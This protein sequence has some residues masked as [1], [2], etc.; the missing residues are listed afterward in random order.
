MFCGTC[1]VAK[2]L[3]WTS[4]PLVLSAFARSRF[5][6]ARTRPTLQQLA[7]PQVELVDPIAVQRARRDQVHRDVGRAARQRPRR[8]TAA[9]ARWSR[10]S[11][12]QSAVPGSSGRW[13]RPGRPPSARC[14]SQQF[15][16]RQER[17][18]QPA[19]LGC[20]ARR[21]SARPRS[22]R[23]D[24]SRRSRSCRSWSAR[25]SAPLQNDGRRAAGR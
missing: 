19:H 5:A 17:R 24:S 21:R 7:E 14:R 15:D 2:L 16:L 12:R 10:R 4:T 8:A 25:R 3:F 11:W 23:P 20:S 9:P 13:P 22:R 1:Q 18:L 6:L